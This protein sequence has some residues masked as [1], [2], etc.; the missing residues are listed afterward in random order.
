MQVK[1]FFESKEEGGWEDLSAA[2][3]KFGG[4]PYDIIIL[5]SFD[6]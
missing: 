2:G 5:L 4:L 6:V 3:C 1:A